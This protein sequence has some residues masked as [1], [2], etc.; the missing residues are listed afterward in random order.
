VTYRPGSR[1]L[2]IVSDPRVYAVFPGGVLR[3]IPSAAAA[4]RLYGEGW[5]KTVND[6]SDAFFSDYDIGA[7]L[8]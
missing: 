2:K 6:L 3:E 5:A 8:I 1:L 7:P 4:V